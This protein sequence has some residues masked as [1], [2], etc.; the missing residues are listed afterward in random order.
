MTTQLLT[1]EQVATQLQVPVETL[2]YWRSKKTGP[3]ALKVGKYLR[4]RQAEVDAWIESLLP[5]SNVTPISSRR[6]A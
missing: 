5:Q 1:I 6:T 4:Y 3:Q 2:Y